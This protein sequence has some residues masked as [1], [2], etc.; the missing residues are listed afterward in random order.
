M[1]KENPYAKT[2]YLWNGVSAFFFSH[3]ITPLHSHNTMQL[4]FDV[5]KNFKCRLSNTDWKIYK[6]LIIQENAIHQLD[7][8]DSIQLII[9]L[10]AGSEITKTIKSKFLT[11][12]QIFSPDIDILDLVKPGELEECL[13]ETNRELLEKIVK[14]LLNEIVD[15]RKPILIDERIKTVI[16]LLA[17]ND[18]EEMTITILAKKVFLSE[19]RLRNLFKNTTGVSLH[20]Y[21][22]WNRIMLAINKILNGATVS[23]AA[24]DCGF[25]DTSHF[26]KMLLQ[27]F[28]V[29]PSQFIKANNKSQLVQCTRY[30]LSV[31]SRVHNERFGD[32]EEVHRL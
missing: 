31:E 11:E 10:D 22:I 15:A 23:E 12:S 17:K 27:M 28:G 16:K 29:T 6:S 3:V 8:N 20:R 19:S 26:H 7:T 1:R 24:L 18:S 4:V 14:Q 9:Y 25:L 30:P 32:T 21:I 5:R 2:L 13:I